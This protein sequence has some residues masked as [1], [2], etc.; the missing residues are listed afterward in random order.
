[1]VKIKEV[2]LEFKM[3]MIMIMTLM[4]RK[5]R[6]IRCKEIFKM[7]W[8]EYFS[9]VHCYN[10]SSNYEKGIIHSVSNLAEF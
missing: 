4:K 5:W 3:I 9:Y 7:V 1:M 6:I 10:I 2:G 8:S